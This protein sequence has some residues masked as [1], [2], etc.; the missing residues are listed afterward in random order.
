DVR[1]GVR[2]DVVGIGREQVGRSEVR[3]DPVVRGA[4]L[5]AAHAGVRDPERGRDADPCRIRTLAGGDDDRH[6]KR[7]QARTPDPS[8]RHKPTLT[9]FRILLYTGRID[10]NFSGSN[11][12][13]TSSNSARVVRRTS[14][15]SNRTSSSWASS[16]LEWTPSER[17]PP[18]TFRG[19]APTKSVSSL[20]RTII[21]SLEI[22]SSRVS[23]SWTAATSFFQS[24]A[25]APSTQ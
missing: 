6:G 23:H 8:A 9:N 1:A 2:P 16:S 12:R 5:G 24:G 13:D 22:H 4:A 15:S 20:R 11:H 14:T 25:L 10:Q 18:L 19:F 3:I 17:V 21:W 7:R